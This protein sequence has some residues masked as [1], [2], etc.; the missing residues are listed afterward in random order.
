VQ[1]SLRENLNQGSSIPY[2]IV[3]ATQFFEFV[4]G[5]ADFPLMQTTCACHLRSSSPWR[6]D[7]VASAVAGSL[8]AHQ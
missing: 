2:S 5:I 6:A 1:K 8:W 4:K 3:R 7:D